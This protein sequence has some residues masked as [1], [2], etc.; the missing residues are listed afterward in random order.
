MKWKSNTSRMEREETACLVIFI[1]LLI[2]V[3]VQ[4]CLLGRF[5]IA[6]GCV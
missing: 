5:R 3:G 4:L 2:C 1:V 6:N